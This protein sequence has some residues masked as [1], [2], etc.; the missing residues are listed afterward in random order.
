MTKHKPVRMRLVPR[1]DVTSSSL[2][3]YIVTAFRVFRP[4]IKFLLMGGLK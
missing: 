3:S 4:Q 1:V 2:E